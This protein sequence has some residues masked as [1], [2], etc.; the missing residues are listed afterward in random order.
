MMKLNPVIVQAYG[1]PKLLKKIFFEET[2]N[3]HGSNTLGFSLLEPHPEPN[4][5]S[6]PSYIQEITQTYSHSF[7][8]KKT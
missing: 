3:Y 1:L 5:I 6:G 8:Q 4:P 2:G 7:S